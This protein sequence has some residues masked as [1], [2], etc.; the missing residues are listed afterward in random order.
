VRTT[1]ALQRGLG[2]T[3]DGMLLPQPAAKILALQQIWEGDLRPRLDDLVE[4]FKALVPGQS[5]ALNSILDA[6]S[7][8]TRVDLGTVWEGISGAFSAALAAAA[9]S[10]STPTG[11]SAHLKSQIASN[12]AYG[13]F[14]KPISAAD[15]NRKNAEFWKRTTD[16]GGP[17]ARDPAR[18]A[19]QTIAELNERNREFW[20]GREGVS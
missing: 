17:A 1:D 14:S 6:E 19:P 15:V 9:V 8:H 12:R 3:R 2:T 20:R 16:T 5:F 13:T 7:S 4:Q 11:D 18:S 10:G